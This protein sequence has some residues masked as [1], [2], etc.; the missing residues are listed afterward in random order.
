ME[1]LL[2][3]LAARIGGRL[4]GNGELPLR[5]VASITEARAGDITFLA[6]PRFADWLSRTA[7]TAV[8]VPAD[9]AP[10][11]R[12]IIRAE[13]P[14]EAFRRA[15]VLFHADRRP[16]PIGVHPSAMIA[17]GVSLGHD[18]AIGP[19][20]V[21]AAGATI[22]DRTVILP[23]VVIGADVRIGCDCLIYPQAVIR[24]ETE[25][26]N[27]VIIHAGAVI[28]DD[29]FGFLTRNAAHG[30]MPQV[31]RVI[32]ESD[33]EIGSN[34]CIDRATLGVTRIRRGTRI[35]NL[36]QIGHNVSI[37]ENSILCALVGIAG[38]TKMGDRV[39]VGGQ[40]GVIHHV[41]IGDDVQIGAQGGVT[42]SIPAATQV[43][44]YPAAPHHLAK[45]MQAALRRLPKALGELRR[46]TD[47]VAD[48]EARA[49]GDQRRPP[50]GE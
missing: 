14:Y 4:E 12:A 28:G 43:S 38:S 5:G 47:R 25:I 48:L 30:K 40:A 29:G 7:A 19:Q 18:V 35:D 26:G 11:E 49:A 23:G 34:S 32:I 36:V 33:V 37:G 20:V 27:A 41:E 46:L 39:T 1:I 44:G 15:V 16:L 9:C 22:G 13:D 2:K 31:G 45:R 50:G 3:D 42:K 17:E 6:N 10:T 24:E 21:I 8:I